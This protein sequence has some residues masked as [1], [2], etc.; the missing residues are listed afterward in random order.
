M[1]GCVE[2]SVGQEPRQRDDTQHAWSGCDH[3][4]MLAMDGGDVGGCLKDHKT[5]SLIKG[6][7]SKFK[8]GLREAL[9]G[10]RLRKITRKGRRS[11]RN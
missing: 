9:R 4:E 7:D 3:H 1:E 10:A 11:E 6:E 5:I 8:R 2:E